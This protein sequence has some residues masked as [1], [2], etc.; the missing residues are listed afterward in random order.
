M[1]NA[2]QV[3]DSQSPMSV[4]EFA[5]RQLAVVERQMLSATELADLVEL[6][7]TGVLQLSGGFQF[8]LWSHDPVGELDR[9]LD[10]IGV[11]SGAA[12]IAENL[13][14]TDSVARISEECFGVMVVEAP[15]EDASSIVE[16]WETELR[17]Q[18]TDDGAGGMIE[19]PTESSFHQ[20]DL[21]T[22]EDNDASEIAHTLISTVEQ[23][24]LRD[25]S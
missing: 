10:A 19:P 5:R 23:A 17:G 16:R 12:K 24:L 20:C 21:P 15:R 11:L 2:D 7:I 8:E 9:H 18:L 1:S 4:A 13:R 22:L 25:A 14:D 6:P 3:A